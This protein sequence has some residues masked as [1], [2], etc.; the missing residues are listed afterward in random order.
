[1]G[2]RVA[3]KIK[4]RTKNSRVTKHKQR[5]EKHDK[6]PAKKPG[7]GNRGKAGFVG[8]VNGSDQAD[9]PAR[10]GVNLAV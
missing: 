9:S 5:A 1:M 6:A 10:E 4:E 2:T 7:A 8:A 3:R